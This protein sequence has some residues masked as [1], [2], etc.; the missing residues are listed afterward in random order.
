MQKMDLCTCKITLGGDRRQVVFRGPLR[1][2]TYPEIDLMRYMHG[3]RYVEDVVVIKTVETTNA[4]E[5]EALRTK[6][7]KSA[8]EAFPGTRP[9]LPLEAPGDVPRNYILDEPVG[10]NAGPAEPVPEEG[11]SSPAKR[12]RAVKVD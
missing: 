3:D 10:E 8:R 9:R 4:A 6:Y 7:G 2:M 12:T 11:Y 1:P 5:V